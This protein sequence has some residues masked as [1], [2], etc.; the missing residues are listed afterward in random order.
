MEVTLVASDRRDALAGG[1]PALRQPL[2]AHGRRDLGSLRAHRALVGPHPQGRPPG[3]SSFVVISSRHRYPCL[4]R[5]RHRRH[6]RPHGHH[7]HHRNR[8]RQ[9]HRTRP[10]VASPGA[11][12]RCRG[13]AREDC[14]SASLSALSVMPVASHHHTRSPH[15]TIAPPQSI[16]PSHTI[17]PSAHRPPPHPHPHPTAN[18]ASRARVYRMRPSAAHH[19]PAPAKREHHTRDTCGDIAAYVTH[20][21]LSKIADLVGDGYDD[22]EGRRWGQAG[23]RGWCRGRTF[24]SMA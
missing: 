23:E 2:R 16:A 1:E 17:A 7:C 24:H 10:R 12:S 20:P 22:A 4:R 14:T 19:T 5:R 11:V 6:R 18:D 8:H 21:V 15:R 9:C 13:N 3:A